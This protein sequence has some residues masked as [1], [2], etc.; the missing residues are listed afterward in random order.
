MF[1]SVS[2][3]ISKI[4]DKATTYSYRN[5]GSVVSGETYVCPMCDFRGPFAPLNGTSGRRNRAACPVCGCRER[6]RLQKLVLDQVLKGFNAGHKACLQ[7]PPDP[8][9]PILSRSFIKFVTADLFP[10][11]GSIKLDMT[12][13]DLPDKS[14]DMVYASH[15]L[16]HIPDD[17]A[18]LREVY[19]VLKPGGIAILPV[20]VLAQKTVDYPEAVATEEY[21]VRAPGQDYFDRYRAV[22]DRVDLLTSLD[23]EPKY[24]TYIYED[25]SRYPNGDNPYRPPLPGIKHVDIVPVCRKGS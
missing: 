3:T 4:S 22:F 23:F 1:D 2:R 16:E 8:M 7:F 19:R 21:H 12:K 20:P 9:S 10:Q 13:I 6:H 11:P 15:V 17:R 25:W 24:Q 18:A 14:F 5:F